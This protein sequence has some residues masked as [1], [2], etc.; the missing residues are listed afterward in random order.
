MRVQ[1]GQQNRRRRKKIIIYIYIHRACSGFRPRVRTCVC[2]CAHARRRPAWFTAP[3]SLC[4][5]HLGVFP[6]HASF[7]FGS[8]CGFWEIGPFGFLCRVISFCPGS[9]ILSGEERRADLPPFSWVSSLV[10]NRPVGRSAC[11]ASPVHAD[12]ST[13][14][15]CGQ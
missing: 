7:T 12:T 4:C 6:L 14:A 11:R 1:R 5:L 13:A 2:T 3:N 10:F 15:F 9:W 8:R